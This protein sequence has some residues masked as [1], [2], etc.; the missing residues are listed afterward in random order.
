MINVAKQ[1]HINITIDFT[2]WN[3]GSYD[4]RI[5]IHLT[6]KQLLIHLSETLEIPFPEKSLFT[7]KIAT[8]SLLLADDDYISDYAVTDGDM[9]IV[10]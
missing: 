10:L 1:S 5:P 8:K 9:F 7:I 3:K 2:S 6:V 4:L